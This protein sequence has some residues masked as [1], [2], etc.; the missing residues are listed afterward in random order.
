MGELGGEWRG[1]DTGSAGAPDVTGGPGLPR[2]SRRQQVS[3]RI[4]WLGKGGGC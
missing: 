2:E 1:P 4:S 3:L